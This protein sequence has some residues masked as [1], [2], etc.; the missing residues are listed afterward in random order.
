MEAIDFETAIA[1]EKIADI[2]SEGLFG[3]TKIILQL[4]KTEGV[5]NRIHTIEPHEMHDNERDRVY[6]KGAMTRNNNR[7][8]LF[9]DHE[10]GDETFDPY[11]GFGELQHSGGEPSFG[12]SFYTPTHE[13]AEYIVKSVKELLR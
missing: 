3:F 13:N 12:E 7:C 2:N 4:F 5:E 1:D 8:Y 11:V 6:L 10:Q 9:V